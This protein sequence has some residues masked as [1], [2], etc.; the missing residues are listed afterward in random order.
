MLGFKSLWTSLVVYYFMFI[1]TLSVK[2]ELCNYLLSVSLR[3]PKDSILTKIF[4]R[5]LFRILGFFLWSLTKQKS[6]Q[7]RQLVNLSLYLFSLYLYY[8]TKM[9]YVGV[10]RSW[11]KSDAVILSMRLWCCWAYS[12]G[13]HTSLFS[14]N[15]NNLTLILIILLIIK[16]GVLEIVRF[17]MSRVICPYTIVPA[18]APLAFKTRNN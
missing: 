8:K 10:R 13:Y 11:R 15:Y 6:Q 17:V 1:S 18:N 9:K 4:Y 12:H 3:E 16:I 5:K 7:L 2:G 14:S